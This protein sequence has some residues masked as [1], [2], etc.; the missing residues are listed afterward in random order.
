MRVFLGV[1]PGFTDLA[2]SAM[3]EDG[4]ILVTGVLCPK[5]LACGKT[6]IHIQRALEK[7]GVTDVIGASYER[8]VTYDGKSNPRSEEILMVTGELR[9]W[10]SDRFLLAPHMWRAIDW[11]N[12]MSKHIYKKGFRNPSTRLDKK[13]SI[14]AAEFVFPDYEF[15]SD[16]EADA[17]LLAYTARMLHDKAH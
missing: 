10:L 15:M 3:K 13:F 16:H 7:A 4:E 14:A 9:F 2:F 12:R 6:P 1:D 11:K 17:S 5:E 8:Y